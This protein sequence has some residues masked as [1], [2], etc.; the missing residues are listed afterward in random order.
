[1]SFV[2]GVVLGLLVGVPVGMWIRSE[3]ENK[4]IKTKK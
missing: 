3:F 2:S 1:M 4:E